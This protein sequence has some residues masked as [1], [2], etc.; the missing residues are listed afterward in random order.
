MGN[1]CDKPKLSLCDLCEN[2]Y[3]IEGG[4]AA[5]SSYTSSDGV[6]HPK[7]DCQQRYCSE[8]IIAIHFDGPQECRSYKGRRKEE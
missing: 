7:S 3:L 6:F 1:S 5:M 4:C 8:L 2:A